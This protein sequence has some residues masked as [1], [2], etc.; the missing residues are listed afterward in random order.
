MK[1]LYVTGESS[2]IFLECSCSLHSGSFFG[3][4]WCELT[5]TRHR[6]QLLPQTQNPPKPQA[7]TGEG[8]ASLWCRE[9]MEGNH[10]VSFSFSGYTCICIHYQNRDVCYPLKY[11]AFLWNIT[12]KKLILTA[13]GFFHSPHFFNSHFWFLFISL[14][15]LNATYR[16][17]NNIHLFPS[18]LSSGCGVWWE[19]ERWAVGS[20]GRFPL[21]CK[22]T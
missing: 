17:W 4:H 20:V 2:T 21:F 11:Y 10:E 12:D 6:G 3:C 14:H 16:N 19:A 5:S 1:L 22:S 15:A 18:L 8:R 13:C 7:Q 9:L